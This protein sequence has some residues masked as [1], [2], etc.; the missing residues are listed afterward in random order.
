MPP[1]LPLP[2]PPTPSPCP[3]PSWP[4]ACEALTAGAAASSSFSACL[5]VQYHDCMSP[6]FCFQPDFGKSYAHRSSLRYTH[7]T[8]SFTLWIPSQMCRHVG[9]VNNCGRNPRTSTARY[10]YKAT[11]LA[12]SDLNTDSV[13]GYHEHICACD[14]MLSWLLFT[15]YHADICTDVR[16]LGDPDLHM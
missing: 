11:N 14:G 8:M 4:C 9:L 1:A 12:L 7:R 3:S 5:H 6:H 13:S 2:S 10:R 15:T 16:R